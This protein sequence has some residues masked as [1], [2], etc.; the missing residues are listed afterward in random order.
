MKKT[1]T[2]VYIED[3]RNDEEIL[4]VTAELSR[5]KNEL[6]KAQDRREGHRNRPAALVAEKTSSE[7][8]RDIAAGKTLEEIN[9]ETT[10]SELQKLAVYCLELETAVENKKIEH[11]LLTQKKAIAI[12][13]SEVVGNYANSLEQDTCDALEAYIEAIEKK[14]AFYSSLRAAGIPSAA[15]PA[16]YVVTP[17]ELRLLHGFDSFS[18][19]DVFIKTRKKVWQID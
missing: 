8:Q 3:I 12:C 17:W 19:A 18:S 7:I 1:K 16:R 9:L 15:L 4:A 13:K 2:D 14:K 6:K 11:L 5:L 10:D